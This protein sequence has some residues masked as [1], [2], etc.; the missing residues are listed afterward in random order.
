MISHDDLAAVAAGQADPQTERRVLAATFADPS[1]RRR[2]EV[3]RRAL[4]TVQA[5]ADPR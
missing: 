1:V 5:F 2:L 4:Q 3:L